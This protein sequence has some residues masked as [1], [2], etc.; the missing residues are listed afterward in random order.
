[1]DVLFSKFEQKRILQS[2]YMAGIAVIIGVVFSLIGYNLP[3]NTISYVREILPD[4]I[5]SSTQTPR[6]SETSDSERTGPL[7][8]SNTTTG[9]RP[10]RDVNSTTSVD[11]ETTLSD[12]HRT[13]VLVFAD[14]RVSIARSLTVGILC[15]GLTFII[16]L[17]SSL[18]YY[19]KLLLDRYDLADIERYAIKHHRSWSARIIIG[20]TSGVILSLLCWFFWTLFGMM[21]SN[22]WLSK[23]GATFV[24]ALYCGI[25]GFAVTYWNIAIRTMNVVSLGLL[26]FALGLFGSFLLSNDPQWWQ[27]SLSYLGYD[28]GADIVFRISMVAVGLMLLT[29]IR[30]LLDTLWIEVLMGHLSKIRHRI[31]AVGAVLICLG[32]MGVGIFPVRVSELSTHLH[33]LSVY[34]AGGLFSL[35]MFGI[36]FIAP[37][38]FHPFFIRVSWGL[39]AFCIGLVG[40]YIADIINFVALEILAFAIFSIWLYLLHEFTLHHLG[41]L[42]RN[43]LKR[44]TQMMIAIVDD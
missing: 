15:T 38:L 22:L 36:G 28:S 29:V 7:P 41:S 44:T 35:G 12:N 26:T 34:A 27:I 21:F 19:R 32:I 25:I 4:S 18:I 33:N 23:T 9:E 10:P 17:L 8:T 42:N 24:T 16:S 14:V 2:L 30:D 39:L 3:E 1:M 31:I 5:I 6:S 40:I 20:A 11:S 43:K 37:G 13:G